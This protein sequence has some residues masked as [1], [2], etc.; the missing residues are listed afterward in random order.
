MAKKRRKPTTR[1]RTQAPSRAAVGTAE[2]AAQ[3]QPGRQA[4]GAGAQARPAASRTGNGASTTATTT[5]RGATPQRT[6]AEKKELARR[7]RDEIRR[8]A[9]RAARVRQLAWITGITAVV[10][11][12]ILF[13]TRP[14]EPATR[15]DTLPGELTTEA[16]W[17]ANADQ[18][19][20]RADAIGLPG[21]GTTMHEHAD[22]QV[23]LRGEQTTVPVGIGIDEADGTLQ[24]LHTH[25]EDGVV[26]M[27]SATERDFTLG[28]FFDVWGVRLSATCIG[29]YCNEG[30]S[31]L[32]V[33]KDGQGVT[34]PIRDVVLDDQSVIV[35]AYGT[36]AELP[37]PIPSTFDFSSVQP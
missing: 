29:G 13:F 24:S 23:F 26:H 1:P 15:P 30:D 12:A 27:E 11:G 31:T 7:Q 36:K 17:P 35:V 4:P 6:R 21:E 5:H 22:V 19:A 37:D 2:R 10:A 16:P 33:F 34:G 9:R 25:S 3:D 32:R 18:A 8:R 14:S 28:E 20:A